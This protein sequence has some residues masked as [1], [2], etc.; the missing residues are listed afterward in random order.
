[1]QSRSM[2]DGDDK[3]TDVTA[4]ALRGWGVRGGEHQHQDLQPDVR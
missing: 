3:Y 1:M 2:F 4:A